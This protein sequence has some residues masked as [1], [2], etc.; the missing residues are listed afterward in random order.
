MKNI[1]QDISNLVS[2]MSD[3]HQSI[4]ELL[5]TKRLAVSIGYINSLQGF[6]VITECGYSGKPHTIN[7]DYCLHNG[8]KPEHI[9]KSIIESEERMRIVRETERMERLIRSRLEFLPNHISN[10]I[11]ERTGIILKT[12]DV[13]LKEELLEFKFSVSVSDNKKPFSYFFTMDITNDELLY[14]FDDLDNLCESVLLR[15]HTLNA[16]AEELLTN[17]K[18]FFSIRNLWSKS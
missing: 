16:Q 5:G 13:T 3:T 11:K 6:M 15:V 14:L 10:Y 17:E 12:L 4:L 9:A 1:K 8:V 7:I 18:T 2:F